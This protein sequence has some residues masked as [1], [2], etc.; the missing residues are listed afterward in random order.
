MKA[1]A[2][3]TL[4]K[5]FRAFCL[6]VAGIG[7]GWLVGLSV[8]P[9][10]HIVITSLVAFAVSIT[11]A[12]AGLKVNP[13]KDDLSGASSLKRKFQVEVDPMPMMLMVVGLALGASLG[14]YG[15]TNNWLGPSPSRFV[16]QWKDTGLDSR[17]ISQRLFDTLYPAKSRSFKPDNENTNSSGEGK[18]KPPDKDN[19]PPSNSPSPNSGRPTKA[20]QNGDP[21]TT[22]P[23]ISPQYFGGVLFHGPAPE[24]CNTFR[25][26]K[27]E[28]L[29]EF[30]TNNR[31]VEKAAKTCKEEIKCLRSLVEKACP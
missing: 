15:R 24:D 23:G 18:E 9:V 7:V 11:S 20:N 14:V 6:L 8:S 12:L 22:S 28:R 13:D 31:K 29:N 19:P 27:D 17:E 30:M 3:K 4:A 25:A 2:K 1:S 21:G 10:I 26:A 5:T 16:E